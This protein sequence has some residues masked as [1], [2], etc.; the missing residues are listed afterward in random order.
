MMKC[1]PMENEP[2]ESCHECEHNE[3][4][5]IYRAFDVIARKT[6]VR[7]DLDEYA[8]ELKEGEIK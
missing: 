3:K 4:C 6:N 8:Q 2:I 1:A 5:T 7:D